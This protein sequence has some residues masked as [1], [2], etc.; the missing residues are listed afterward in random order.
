MR[1]RRGKRKEIG[2]IHIH[3]Y[4]LL[5]SS[6]GGERRKKGRKGEKRKW[7]TPYFS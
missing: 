3:N 2:N 1:K 5:I 4:L 6:G 7:K